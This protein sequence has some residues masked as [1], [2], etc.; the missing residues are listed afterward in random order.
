TTGGKLAKLSKKYNIPIEELKRQNNLF[1]NAISI[2]Q[3]I[4]IEK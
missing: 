4:L 1:E 3:S 2:G